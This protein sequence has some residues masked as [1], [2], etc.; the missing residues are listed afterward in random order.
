V[1][2]G[3]ILAN[4]TQVSDVAPGP[5]VMVSV[6][7]R[8]QG[9]EEMQPLVKIIRDT[10]SSLNRI[11]NGEVHNMC[12]MIIIQQSYTKWSIEQQRR[13]TKA[14]V[15]SGARR[16]KHPLLTGHTH[17]LEIRYTR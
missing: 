2:I 3:K 11:S 9:M 4:M 6:R 14:R 17:L 16:S 5:L 8:I 10:I 7:I 12:N 15:G 13:P 1:F